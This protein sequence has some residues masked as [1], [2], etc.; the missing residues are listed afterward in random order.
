MKYKGVKTLEVLEGADNYNNWIAG[1][2][3]K[4]INSPALE[5]GAG[6]GNISSYFKEKKNLVITDN[7]EELVSVLRNKFKKRKNISVEVLDISKQLGIINNK[8]K[9]VYSVNVLEHIKDDLKALRNMNKLLQKKGRVVLLVP[10]KK[11]A[12]TKLDESL[13]HIKRYE[14]QELNDLL[15]KSN[16]QVEHLEYFNMVG[17]ASWLLRDRLSRNHNNLKKS[18]V[19]TFDFI[20]PFL[21]QIEPQ[22]GLPIGIS[23][24]AVGK[25]K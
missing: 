8:F 20:V 21:K 14:K 10:A 19:K 15:E 9:T 11:R 16:F 6:T 5:I 23:L 12:Y 1:T 3:G 22:R 18:H 13:G 2:I 25:K 4:Y 17:L 24:I 7:D